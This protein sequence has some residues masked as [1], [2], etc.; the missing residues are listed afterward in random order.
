MRASSMKALVGGRTQRSSS[1]DTVVS[2]SQ[3]KTAKANHFSSRPAM[4]PPCAR[5]GGAGARKPV[6]QMRFTAPASPV[7]A[8]GDGSA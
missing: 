8:T 4:L 5:Q 7:I 6:R 3:A 1:T 2:S